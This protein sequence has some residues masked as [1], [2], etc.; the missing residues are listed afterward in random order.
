[1]K[2]RVFLAV[3]AVAGGVILAW[4]G[5]ASADSPPVNGSNTSP[6]P[7]LTSWT[8]LKACVRLD[9]SRDKDRGS[10]RLI[11]VVSPQSA[12]TDKDFYWNRQTTVSTNDSPWAC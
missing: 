7:A 8:G 9:G 4:A 3:T 2:A 10:I 1:L 6:Y 12:R 11:D 5:V